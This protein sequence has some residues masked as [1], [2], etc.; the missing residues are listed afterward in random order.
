MLRTI[1]AKRESKKAKLIP[2]SMFPGGITIQIKLNPRAFYVDFALNVNEN[3]KNAIYHDLVSDEITKG[4]ADF[5]RRYSL[6]NLHL[7]TVQFRYED[8]ALKAVLDQTLLGFN[9]F[10]TD[11]KRLLKSDFWEEYNPQK[12]FYNNIDQKDVVKIECL[13]QSN[14]AMYSPYARQLERYN[15]AIG[16]IQ[17]ELRGRKYPENYHVIGKCSSINTF[18]PENSNFFYQEYKKGIK[19][20][21]ESEYCVNHSNYSVNSNINTIVALWDIIQRKHITS[22]ANY[23]AIADMI[24]CSDI[25]SAIYNVDYIKAFSSLVEYDDDATIYSFA[26]KNQIQDIKPKNKEETFK[27]PKITSK[28]IYALNFESITTNASNNLKQ[29]SL[30]LNFQDAFSV[31]LSKIGDYVN[32]DFYYKFHELMPIRITTFLT[33]RNKISLEPTGDGRAQFTFSAREK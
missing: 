32:Q 13:L 12:V 23:D 24:D 5:A 17:F 30:D 9:N 28:T 25:L 33:F 19:Q 22:N 3:I 4:N 18:G 20:Q 29:T 27:V 11:D 16:E 10:S 8:E 7:K 26:D 1:G 21:K 14:L 6:S 2:L 15:K 31:L